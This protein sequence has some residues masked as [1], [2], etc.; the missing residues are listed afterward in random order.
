MEEAQHLPDGWKITT[1]GTHYSFKNGLNKAKKFFG[2]GTP[3]VNYMD[4]FQHQRLRVEHIQG[5][6]EVTSE[7]VRNYSAQNGDAFFTRTSETVSEIGM[8][9]V[10]LDEVSDA[11]F[12][13]FVL[14]GRPKNTDL[15]P[16]F[17]AYALRSKGVRDQ[18]EALATYTTRALTNG[19]SLSKSVF[20]IPVEPSEQRAI[21][22]ALSDIDD[23]LAS[24]HALIAKKEAVKQGAMQELLS[25]KRRL[26]GHSASLMTKKLSEM[27]DLDPESL[28]SS[29]PP[30]W[31]F[32]YIS[33]ENATQGRL[34][35]Y[36]DQTFATAPSRARR[37]VR[38]HDVLFG[39]VRPNLKSHCIVEEDRN[40][41]VASTGFCVLR[42][43]EKKADPQFLYFAVMG[44][45]V[46]RQIAKII[47][48]SNYPA[49]SS[50]DV[51][52]V[53]I[54]APSLDEQREI[55]AALNNAQKEISALRVKADKLTDIREAMTQQ[56]LAGRI[57]LV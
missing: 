13:G 51:G 22:S 5:S 44:N 6:V 57:R 26:A 40:D 36:T 12:S 9:S 20:P 16:E 28:P 39:T 42:A 27:A 49:V 38:S 50:K 11:V 43:K 30:D 18:I 14:R 46:A 19:G 53:V 34:S 24:L 32:R 45:L 56:L 47:A 4:V 1:I 52:S 17:A 55:A 8:A 41:W 21:A 33:L 54:L 35:G 37:K 15:I 2:H 23:L 29:T 10:L 31:P 25:G 48:G 3:I 7:E